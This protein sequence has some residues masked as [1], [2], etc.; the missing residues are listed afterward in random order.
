MEDLAT[1]TKFREAVMSIEEMILKE[2]GSLAGHDTEQLAPV[3]HL[4]ADGC[5]MRSWTCPPGVLTVSKIHK[6]SHPIFMLYGD[7][8]VM[9]EDGIVRMQGANYGVTPV[10]TKRVLYTHAE[11][12]WVAVH[13][14]DE[15]DSDKIEE[16]VIAKDFDDPAIT[17]VDL[18]KLMEAE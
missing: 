15:T 11:T 1:T 2:P 17:T 16:Y 13:V 18:A 9:T 10:G 6:T 7:V 12:K 8:S 14:T 5:V 4:F 3:A